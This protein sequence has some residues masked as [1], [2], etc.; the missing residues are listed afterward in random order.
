M[1]GFTYLGLLFAKLIQQGRLENTRIAD[2]GGGGV[3]DHADVQLRPLAVGASVDRADLRVAEIGNRT[4][5]DVVRIEVV[6]R[7]EGDRLLRVLERRGKDVV[8]VA[9]RNVPVSEVG[10]REHIQQGLPAGI[11]AGLGD[12]VA[13]ELRIIVERVAHRFRERQLH[14]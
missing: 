12:E 3:I 8:V 7:L 13:R 6:V 10:Q 2:A 1:K 5:E 9:A 4:G 11:D 14:G